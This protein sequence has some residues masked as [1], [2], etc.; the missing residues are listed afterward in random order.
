MQ[1]AAVQRARME[2]EAQARLAEMA[3]RQE[4]ERQLHALSQDQHKKRLVGM[5]IGLGVLLV[6]GGGGLGY[7]AV[8]SHNQAVAAQAQARELQDQ[9]DKAQQDKS[10]IQAAL[11][12]AQADNDQ[13]KIAQ[14]QQELQAEQAKLQNL[15]TSQKNRGGGGGGGAAKPTQGTGGGSKGP[16]NCTPGDPLCSCL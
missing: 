14:L 12:K 7:W 4:H 3:S 13:G 15:Q 5:L 1:E 16:C 6:V 11:A 10:R 2:A 9:I 8:E